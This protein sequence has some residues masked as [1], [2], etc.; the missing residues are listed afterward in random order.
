MST[1]LSQLGVNAFIEAINQQSKQCKAGWKGT[2][3]F[4]LQISDAYAGIRFK[5]IS[6]PIR[7]LKQMIGNPPIGFGTYGFK[8]ELIDD[9]QP[10]RHYIAFVF[11]GFWL[12]YP[13]AGLFLYIWEALGVLRHGFWGEADMKLGWIGIKHGGQVRRNGPA[14]LIE[15]IRQD[16]QE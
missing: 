6:H 13:L 9:P 14:V 3:Q 4:I 2:I 5:D 15:L 10:M 16:L 12:P 11:V 8:R 7:F 1:N